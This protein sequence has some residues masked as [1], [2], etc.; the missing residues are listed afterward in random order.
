MVTLIFAVY[1]AALI[2]ALLVAGPLSDAV[3]RRAV[4]LPAVALAALGSLVFT[5]AAGTGWLFAA[6][7][8]QG[9]AV[10]AASGPLT[11]AL[12]DLEPAA[13]RTWSPASI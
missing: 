2:P 8:L 1:V 12:T 11:A 13:A 7:I 10:G 3:G 6:R 5:L 4:L 9:P